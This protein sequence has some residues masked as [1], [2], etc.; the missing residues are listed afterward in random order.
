MY[1]YTCICIHVYVYMYMCTC[2]CIY[3]YMYI[4]K[5][6]YVLYMRLFYTYMHICICVHMYIYTDTC[7]QVACTLMYVHIY[8]Y[9][10]RYMPPNHPLMD[11]TVL[12]SHKDL[13]FQMTDIKIMIRDLGAEVPCLQKPSTNLKRRSLLKARVSLDCVYI[14]FAL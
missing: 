13:S 5:C 4:F 9:M 8:I 7:A 10:Y 2:I 3:V 14:Y 11:P 12:D 6:A 1:I